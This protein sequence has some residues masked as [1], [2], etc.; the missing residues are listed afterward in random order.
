MELT[1]PSEPTALL[2]VLGTEYLEAT[3]GGPIT[4]LSLANC[5]RLKLDLWLCFWM[6]TERDAALLAQIR[7]PSAYHKVPYG[8]LRRDT[9][10]TRKRLVM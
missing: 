7:P 9:H 10:P 5:W 3:T 8:E 4:F 1:S 2:T 6:L